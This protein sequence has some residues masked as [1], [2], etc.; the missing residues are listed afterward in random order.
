MSAFNLKDFQRGA[1]AHTDAGHKVQF[2]NNVG[3]DKIRVAVSVDI[4]GRDICTITIPLSMAHQH[5][6]MDE[7]LHEGK[8][9]SRFKFQGSTQG[10]FTSGNSANVENLLKPQQRLTQEASERYFAK[11]DEQNKKTSP[12]GEEQM[13]DIARDALQAFDER[14]QAKRR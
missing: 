9:A 5:I 10:Q 3:I 11:L 13:F 2:V 7:M 1:L 8:R 6:T 4:P 12:I 14:I